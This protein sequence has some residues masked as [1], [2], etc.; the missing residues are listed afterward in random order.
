MKLTGE[1]T[2]S[3]EEILKDRKEGKS[4]E[5]VKVE[6]TELI[7]KQSHSVTEMVKAAHEVMPAVHKK[8]LMDEEGLPEVFKEKWLAS[9]EDGQHAM[10]IV[11]QRRTLSEKSLAVLQV[12]RFITPGARFHQA[13]LEQASYTGQLIDL[14]LNYQTSKIELE[15]K[16]YKYQKKM[17]KLE[18]AKEAD[19]DTFLLEKKMQKEQIALVRMAMDLAGTQKRMQNLREEI[20][21]WTDIK[22]KLYKEA[23]DS[24]EIWSPD[25]VDGPAGLQEIPL[26][27]RHIQNFLIQIQHGEGSDISSVLNIQGLVLTAFENGLKENKLGLYLDKLPEAQIQLVWKHLYGTNIQVQKLDGFMVINTNNSQLIFPTTLQNWENMRNPQTLDVKLDE[28]VKV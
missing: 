14:N 5:L 8:I 15:E 28:P 18:K 24:G 25:T 27:L 22:E 26:V 7:L 12:N 17:E 2:K 13:N 6:P 19:E 20:A 16:L 4:T 3:Y 21:E 11:P 1:F 23:M 10:E 9:I